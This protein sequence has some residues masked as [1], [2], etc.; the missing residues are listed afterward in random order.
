MMLLLVVS[1]STFVAAK[2]LKGNPGLYTDGCR[3]QCGVLRVYG[4][5]SVQKLYALS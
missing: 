4:I 5:R 3:S 1:D 2:I